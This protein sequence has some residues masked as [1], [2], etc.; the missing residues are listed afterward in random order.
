MGPHISP[1]ALSLTSPTHALLGHRHGP[2]LAAQASD[3]T[4]SHA[5]AQPS[6]GPPPPF[7]SLSHRSQTPPPLALSPLRLKIAIGCSPFTLSPLHVTP[8]AQKHVTP[9]LVLRRC[10]LSVPDHQSTTSSP[11]FVPKRRCRPLLRRYHL[12]IPY[13][14]STA[15]PHQ[16]LR[17]SITAIL[18]SAPR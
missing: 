9:F 10:C 3:P 17:Q 12:S 13:H 14:Q 16:N 15:S 5:D 7:D 18:S 4:T 1:F 8:T 6:I 2:V 11:E